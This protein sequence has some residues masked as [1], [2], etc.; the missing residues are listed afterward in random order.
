M[1]IMKSVSPQFK[2]NEKPILFE[3][4]FI[5]EK[6]NKNHYDYGKKYGRMPT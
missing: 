5:N 2:S 1:K 3:N 6:T 4:S